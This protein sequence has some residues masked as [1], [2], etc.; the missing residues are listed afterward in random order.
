MNTE[1]LYHTSNMLV[2]TVYHGI[3]RLKR[4]IIWP[5]SFVKQN[6]DSRDISDL[7]AQAGFEHRQYECETEDG[8]LLSLH[9]VVNKGA[10]NVVYFQHGVLDN[11]QTWIVHGSDSSA[12]YQA[13]R[14]G[15]DVFMGNFRGVY[16]RRLASWKAQS[17]VSY[18]NYNIDHLGKYDLAAFMKKIIEVKVKEIKQLITQLDQSENLRDKSSFYDFS[19]F[20]NGLTEEELEAEIRSKIKITYVGHSM[21]GMTLPIYIITSNAAGKPHNVDQAVLMSPAGFHARDRVTPYMHYV[22]IFFYYLL[23]RIVDHIALPDFMIGLL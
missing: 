20:T 3:Q 6:M 4:G 2:E 16:P 19:T 1:Y 13:H 9:R 12:G 18:W 8:Y 11:A 22:G 15:Y 14:L 7:V 23:P 10:F 5:F 21:G 17:G